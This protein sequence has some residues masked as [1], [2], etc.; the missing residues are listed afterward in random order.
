MA[1]AGEALGKLSA[2]AARAR[3]LWNLRCDDVSGGLLG[4][5]LLTLVSNKVGRSQRLGPSDH[6]TGWWWSCP[7]VLAALPLDLRQLGCTLHLER[8]YRTPVSTEPLSSKHAST[9]S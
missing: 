1:G 4:R 6:E 9:P 5:T 3:G 8:G 7:I 2:E